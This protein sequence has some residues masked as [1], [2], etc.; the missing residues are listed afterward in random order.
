MAWV[1]SGTSQYVEISANAALNLPNGDWTVA[2]WAQ[3]STRAGTG[4]DYIFEYQD[5]G[6]NEFIFLRVR[7][8][9]AT[10]PNVAQLIIIDTNGYLYQL[11]DAGTFWAS[12]TSP[13]HIAIR[14]SSGTFSIWYNGSSAASSTDATVNAIT[15]T[16]G[17]WGIG[18]GSGHLSLFN[19]SIWE[20]AKWDRA[21]SDS[22][23]GQLYNGL[24]SGGGKS[25]NSLSTNLIWYCPM[26]S[27]DYT[28][29]IVPLTVT[30]TNTTS[31]AHPNTV[32][33][34]LS[35]PL[36]TNTPTFY[37]ATLAQ[38]D[39][40]SPPL[41]TNTPT[42][43][44]PAFVPGSVNL[45]PPL[46]TNT[47]VFYSPAFAP[48]YDLTAPLLTNTPTFY[49]PALEATYSLAAPLLTNTPVFPGPTFAP[50]SVSLIAPLL[51]NT[52]TFHSPTFA[53]GQVSLAPPLLNNAPSFYGVTLQPTGPQTIEMPLLTNTPV[54]Y[55][56]A[57]A[58]KWV[59]VN[60]PQSTTWQDVDVA[61]HKLGE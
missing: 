58:H 25:P 51:T 31:G 61:F 17:I 37:G 59:D 6:E 54:F 55:S 47:P 56:P 42:F 24:A 49:G 9:S 16:S 23:I 18:E 41:L 26:Y 15:P 14:R 8:A 2:G 52:P 40:L 28:E 12:N 4:V 46:L 1:F 3:F 27:A 35:P 5:A 19:G 53:P 7:Q 60:P 32:A 20:W 11:D 45:A 48:T 57:I 34:P 13:A 33:Y 38:A 10:N 29:K 44:G 30:N 39:T 43:Y 50:G 22:E 21:L 36:I